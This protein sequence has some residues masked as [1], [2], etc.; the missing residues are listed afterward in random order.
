MQNLYHLIYILLSSHSLKTLSSPHSTQF[1]PKIFVS[2]KGSL[3]E[4]YSLYL[5]IM[6]KGTILV[7][8]VLWT[9]VAADPMKNCFDSANDFKDSIYAALEKK[10]LMLVID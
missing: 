1:K 5:L 10:D 6:I 8:L 4:N 3:E 7:A 2:S 9:I